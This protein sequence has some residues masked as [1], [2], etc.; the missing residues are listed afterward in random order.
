MSDANFIQGLENLYSFAFS[1]KIVE[2]TPMLY[3]YLKGEL[4]KIDNI[5]KR[6]YLLG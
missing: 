4:L 3:A 1:Y 5:Q 2:K 6:D